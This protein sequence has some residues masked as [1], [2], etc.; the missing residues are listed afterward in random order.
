MPLKNSLGRETKVNQITKSFLIGLCGIELKDR[1][2]LKR[3]LA[4]TEGRARTYSLSN[5]E[6]DEETDILI[7]NADDPDAINEWNE[8]YVGSNGVS[9]CATLFASR[10]NNIKEKYCNTSL[11]FFP[12]RILKCLDEVTVKNFKYAPE[13]RIEEP[14]EEAESATELSGIRN[15]NSDLTKKELETFIGN[16]LDKG[17]VNHSRNVL[18]VD[19]SLPVRKAL[20]MKLR[21]MNYEVHHASSGREAIFSIQNNH[22]DF[23]FLDVVMPGMDGYE[24][25]KIIKR[26]KSTKRIPVVMLTSRSSPFDKVKGKL[27]GCNSYLTKPVEHEKFEKVVAGLLI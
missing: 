23:I 9:M 27:A 2:V 5:P 25:C 11:P 26:N 19:D 20:D 1:N 14:I 17:E 21:L 7:V 16:N 3:I 4:I 10:N 15:Y 6:E 12:T 18:I 8:K 22:F 13:L 24:V